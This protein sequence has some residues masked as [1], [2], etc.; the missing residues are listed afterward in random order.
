ALQQFDKAEAVLA[1]VVSKYPN[2][3]AAFRADIWLGESLSQRNRADEALKRYGVVIDSYKSSPNKPVTG[4]LAAKA[5]RGEGWV[6]WGQQKFNDS[7]QS[8]A[9]ALALAQDRGLKREA[10]LKLGE[11]YV[12]AGQ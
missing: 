2:T 3:R 1:S 5:W 11:S 7:A 12:R 9:Q 8:F 4:E 6:Y 10:M